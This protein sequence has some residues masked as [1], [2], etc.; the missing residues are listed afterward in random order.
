[1]IVGVTAAGHWPLIQAL[2]RLG[3]YVEDDHEQAITEQELTQTNPFHLVRN[4]YHGFLRFIWFL[5][6]PSVLYHCNVR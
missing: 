1:M 3:V 4:M 5:F 2:S 6:F